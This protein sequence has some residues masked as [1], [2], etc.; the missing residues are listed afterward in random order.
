MDGSVNLTASLSIQK[1]KG[2]RDPYG[3][4]EIEDSLLRDIGPYKNLVRFASNSFEAKCISTSF[5][6]LNN[7]R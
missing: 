5:P 4:F 7:L 1:E 6:L 2:R 3:I